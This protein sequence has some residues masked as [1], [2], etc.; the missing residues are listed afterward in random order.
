M[1]DLIA[2]R[3]RP[4]GLLI[5]AAVLLVSL[6][7]L[8]FFQWKF[9]GGQ[10]GFYLMAVLLTAVALRPA[11]WGDSRARFAVFA[12]LVFAASILFDRGP[13]AWMMFNVA[14]GMAVLLPATA[15]FD[16]GWRWFQRL[17][18][19]GLRAPV[20]PLFDAIR[21]AK[22]R[23]RPARRFGLRRCI[24][25]V[26]LPLVGSMVIFMLFVAA[27]PVL[28][29]LLANLRFQLPSI[30]L[31]RMI[32]WVLL[33]LMAWTLLHPRPTQK[34][35]GTFDGRGDLPLP[36]VSVSSVTLSLVAFNLLFA[37]QNLMDIAYLG[38]LLPMPGGVTLAD[39][40]HRGAYPLI[41]TALLAAAFVLVAL[42]PGSTTASLPLIRRMLVLWIAQNVLLVGSSIVRTLDYVAAYSLTELRIAALAWMGLVALGLIFICWRM[43]R[44]KSAAWLINAN[45]AAAGLV[46]TAFCFVDAGAIAASWN[47]GHAREVGGRGAALDLCYLNR[48]GASA[49]E[50]LVALEQRDNL[51]PVFRERVQSVRQEV[52]DRLATDLQQGGW[53]LLG[54]Y[55]F[56]RARAMLAAAPMR[57]PLKPTLRNCEGSIYIAPVVEQPPV[58]PPPAANAATVEAPLHG[59]PL[60]GAPAR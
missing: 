13:L 16:D 25:V 22:A 57:P 43:L 20:G 26:A 56:D 19:M 28:E 3:R 1:T 17:V 35:L 36:G 41:I 44:G 23:R 6:G 10:L 40:A 60:T 47:V 53:T 7:D 54:R 50:P 39:Y 48:L 24:P 29:H 2:L 8:L 18:L 59:R 30:D 58:D 32:L 11:I 15:R 33:F 49:L 51:Q 42:Q 27:N 31:G 4:F 52:M 9:Y 5:V 14:A 55:R 38:G 46:L 37:L 21:I 34:L 12:G 45:F